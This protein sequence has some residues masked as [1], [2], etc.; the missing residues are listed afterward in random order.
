[1]PK[2][3][4]KVTKYV[5]KKRRICGLNQTLIQETQGIHPRVSDAPS[6]QLTQPEHLSHLDFRYRSRSKN[7]QLRPV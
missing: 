3:C 6:E 7:P 5:G 1:M 4:A 2:K